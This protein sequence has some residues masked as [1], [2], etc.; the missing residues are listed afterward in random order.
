M[1]HK[2]RARKCFRRFLQ[3][4][5]PLVLVAALLAGG[6][7]LFD[8]YCIFIDGNI[9][10][11]DI[12]QLDLS[13][14]P[15]EQPDRITELTQLTQLDLRGTGISAGEYEKLQ[16]ALPRCQILWEP[17]FQGQYYPLDT[18]SLTVTALTQDDVI[19]LDYFTQLSAVDAM[20]CQD[21]E[22][23]MALIRRRPECQVTYQVH[24]GQEDYLPQATFLTVTDEDVTELAAMLPYLPNVTGV[25]FTGSVDALADFQQL[26]TAFPHI[27]FDY[28]ID[29]HGQILASNLVEA[30]FSGLPLTQARD[31]EAILPWLPDLTG[32][33]LRGCPIPQ[34]QLAALADRWE[35][36]QFTWT[37]RLGDLEV[38]TDVQTLDLSG[39]PFTDTQ[40]ID[41]VLPYFPNL[42]Q[43]LMLNCGIGNAE[44]DALNRKYEDIQ[45]VWMVNIGPSFRVRTDV[46]ALIPT[47]SGAWF[48]DEDTY[49]LRYCTE[50][51]VLDLGHMDITNI[52][53]AAFMPKLRYL[54]V[55]D[56]Q[57]KS[58]EP[59]RGLE[60]LIYLEAFLTHVTDYS[61]LLDCPALE[62]LNISW[63]YG[64]FEPLCQMTQLKRLWWGGT[65]HSYQAVNALTTQLSNT[66]LV[67][68]DGEST[69]SGW[70]K[71][72]HYYEMRNLLGMYYME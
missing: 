18:Q 10:R 25:L 61:P 45:I 68:Y 72:P 48:T 44:M 8:R 13:G 11:R 9:Y 3:I 26:K 56:S 67:L 36:I 71:H 69:G 59:L 46:T 37:V 24:I 32:V 58:L 16:A 39:I 53:F 6:Y 70:R 30:N 60:N 49:N 1:P 22:A 43:V 42:T 55:A 52:D 12:T 14:S 47:Q 21:Y 50:L 5:I 15:V 57:V 54:I 35:N 4:S 28:Q 62:D 64:S 20:D 34:E 41:S 27:I 2:V 66:Q 33:S 19:Y 7:L 31:V 40:E 51:V 29:F 65:P 17:W 38:S 63:T 23:I